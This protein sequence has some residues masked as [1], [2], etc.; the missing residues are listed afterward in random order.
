MI[1]GTL[2]YFWLL[3]LGKTDCLSPF[4]G[5]GGSPSY[6]MC[7]D[8]AWINYIEGGI[9][10]A[11]E[12]WPQSSDLEN[13]VVTKFNA[14]CSDGKKLEAACGSS[15]DDKYKLSSF[16]SEEGLYSVQVYASNYIHGLSFYNRTSLVGKLNDLDG[17]IV[18]CPESEVITGLE[19]RCGFWM[20]K[21]VFCCR[22][23]GLFMVSGGPQFYEI[24]WIWW[25]FTAIATIAVATCYKCFL[26]RVQKTNEVKSSRK[27]ECKFLDCCTVCYADRNG[28]N[29]VSVSYQ[30]D[31]EVEGEGSFRIQ[32]TDPPTLPGVEIVCNDS[33]PITDGNTERSSVDFR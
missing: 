15:D 33:V 28:E 26:Y 6:L 10:A 21:I 16:R 17:T 27:V 29:D 31:E 8:G 11:E 20:D 14:I 1:M 19:M 2:T 5:E 18:E 22:S 30:R 13:G 23:E 7:S 25:A 3:L 9:F 4:G 12:Y 32:D 24:Q